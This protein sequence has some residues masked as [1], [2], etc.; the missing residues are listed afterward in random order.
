MTTCS[1]SVNLAQEDGAGGVARL[2]PALPQ[3]SK[4]SDA[5]SVTAVAAPSFNSSRRVKSAMQLRIPRCV[6]QRFGRTGRQSDL[7]SEGNLS[8]E[9]KTS[10]CY[11]GLGFIRPR[12][13]AGWQIALFT[14]L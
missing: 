7:A 11:L 6:C 4:A 3:P 14:T 9:L 10:Q 1:M 12:Q 13:P 5:S 8:S 2:P